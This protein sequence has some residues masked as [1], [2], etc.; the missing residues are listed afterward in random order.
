MVGF[1]NR[2]IHQYDTFH[3]LHIGKIEKPFQQNCF[4]CQNTL[5]Y[6]VDAKFRDDNYAALLGEG[7]QSMPSM[8]GIDTKVLLQ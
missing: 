3:T 5:R 2:I 7:F 4:H 8:H 1:S 6:V